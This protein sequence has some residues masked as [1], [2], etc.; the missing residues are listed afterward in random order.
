MGL[1]AFAKSR[2]ANVALLFSLTSVPALMIVGM[3]IDF[4]YAF[5]NK[6]QL[7][8]A[9]DAAALSAASQF[10]RNGYTRMDME[11]YKKFAQNWLDDNSQRTSPKLEEMHICLPDRRDC[12][13]AN[14][15][16]LKS[17]Q[18]YVRASGTSPRSIS[19][20]VPVKIAGQFDTIRFSTFAIAT[21]PIAAYLDI[22]LLID[23]SASMGLGASPSDQTGMVTARG[24]AFACHNQDTSVADTVVN[25]GVMDA[26]SRGFSLRIDAVKSALKEIVGKAQA[27]MAANPAIH[28][29]FGLYAF[30]DNFYKLMDPTAQFGSASDTK[31]T[32]LYGAINSLD[33]ARYDAGTAT[34]Y[35]MQ[36]LADLLP[37]SGTGQTQ[38]T[39]QTMVFFASDGTANALDNHQGG[40]WDVAAA[41]WAGYA[42]APYLKWIWPN[43]GG[44]GGS[45]NVS[46]AQPA[47]PTG[48]SR[49]RGGPA[50]SAN[51]ACPDY[52][53]L[54]NSNNISDVGVIQSR[55]G[56]LPVPCIA[57]PWWFG[58]SQTLEGQIGAPSQDDMWVQP[59]DPAWCAPLNNKSTLATL[60]TTY[61]LPPPPQSAYINYVHYAVAP[62]IADKMMACA[63]S[64]STAFMA[65]DASGISTALNA[66]FSIALE[67]LRL[68]M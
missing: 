7:R 36:K 46:P 47:T 20:M 8:N 52:P 23:R 53:V 58:Y 10:Q 12:T 51:V 42:P 64:P 44:P 67:K 35:A 38:A 16:T 43:G 31:P 68:A 48:A 3:A 49:A 22:Y 41:N 21:I 13:T 14:G 17:G 54:E 32:T 29:R 19:K 62:K 65:S 55:F 40:A 34:P 57:Q 30:D 1:R 37:P 66:M 24:C 28:V 61:E 26:H 4:S 59:V 11:K 25:D 33:I 60:Y 45:S 50:I 5:K 63:S 15:L 39:A 18:L 6:A 2:R 56:S 9:A 27:A